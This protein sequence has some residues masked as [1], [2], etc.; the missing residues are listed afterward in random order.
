LIQFFLEIYCEQL[1]TKI[2]N[3]I[4]H[5]F[6]IPKYSIINLWFEGLDFFEISS[7]LYHS[8]F[9]P[10]GRDIP[11]PKGWLK[12]WPVPV[13]VDSIFQ[14]V[15]REICYLNSIPGSRWLFGKIEFWEFKSLNLNFQLDYLYKFQ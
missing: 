9:D 11:M 14:S 5:M 7:K 2:P 12:E 4:E 1:A 15:V 6:N 13:E 8:I 3:F 10:R